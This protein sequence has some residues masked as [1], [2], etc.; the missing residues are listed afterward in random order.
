MRSG[1]M[2]YYNIIYGIPGD[3]VEEYQTILR[4]IPLLYHLLPPGLCS[5]V[6]VTRY[7]PLAVS[8]EN[9]GFEDVKLAPLWRYDIL[10]TEAFRAD[11]GL[12]MGEFCYHFENYTR[13]NSSEEMKS[14]YKALSMQCSHWIKRYHSARLSYEVTDDGIIFEDTRMED[15]KKVTSFGKLHAGI[16]ELL[17]HGPATPSSLLRRFDAQC[18]Q[19]D[20]MQILEDFRDARVVFDENDEYVAI[21][22]PVHVYE[23]E[24]CCWWIDPA[25]R[26]EATF[27]QQIPLEP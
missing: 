22:F 5:W 18:S 21:A 12:D 10:F 17:T 19:A 24:T 23:S 9:F 8:P 1:I 15:K 3:T 27:R 14:L 25:R 26:H 6:V 4:R 16:Y 7:S 13:K 11:T 2:V 20:L